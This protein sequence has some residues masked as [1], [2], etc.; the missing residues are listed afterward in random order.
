MFLPSNNT[1][2]KENHMTNNTEKE[3]K[4]DAWTMACSLL[5]GLRK[6][7]KVADAERV[8]AVAAGGGNPFFAGISQANQTLE[9][10]NTAKHDLSI[11]MHRIAR[12]S[13]LTLPERD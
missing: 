6:A 5:V 11:E 3:D 13:A 9:M 7:A 10:L 2:L 8:V 4:M 1:K 12:S